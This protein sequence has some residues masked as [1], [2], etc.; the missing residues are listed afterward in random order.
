M[1]AP[2]KEHVAS[3]V[4]KYLR[5]CDPNVGRSVRV[6]WDDVRLGDS[7]DSWWWVPVLFDPDPYKRHAYYELLSIVEEQIEEKEKMSVFLIPR[8]TP[9][10]E[11]N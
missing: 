2:S 1:V 7:P 6:D 11:E 8:M 4:Q 10:V 3:L 9:S 5:D